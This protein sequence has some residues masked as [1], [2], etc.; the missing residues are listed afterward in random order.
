LCLGDPIYPVPGTEGSESNINGKKRTC[1]KIA[2]PSEEE[3]MELME[4]YTKA[5]HSLF[6]QYKDEAGYG[7][8]E[9][10]IL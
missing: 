3:V 1:K 2:N 6:E 7:N 4:R 9:L 5:I 10:E 8:D